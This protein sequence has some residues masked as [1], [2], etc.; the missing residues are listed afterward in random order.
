LTRRAYIE[1]L[2]LKHHAQTKA[3]DP[4]WYFDLGQYYHDLGGYEYLHVAWARG[5][6]HLRRGAKFLEKHLAQEDSDRKAQ[7]IESLS[8][9]LGRIGELFSRAAR[10]CRA[11]DRLDTVKKAELH[12]RRALTSLKRNETLLLDLVQAN[13]KN[14]EYARKLGVA[15]ERLAT[16]Y[17]DA[18]NQAFVRRSFFL[19][20]RYKYQ[21][22]D[23]QSDHN[24]FAMRKLFIVIVNYYLKL[25]QLAKAQLYLRR[26]LSSVQKRAGLP[27]TE[28]VNQ[29]YFEQYHKLYALAAEHLNPDYAGVA[30]RLHANLKERGLAAEY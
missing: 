10:L 30:A 26:A 4:S 23:K 2:K 18:S 11:S 16:V 22:Y 29:Y 13:P 1:Y 15:Y 25:G 19:A 21:A 3:D 17:A 12:S 28:G 5:L 20:F 14:I 7:A 27:V 6:R 8:Q 24:G 9:N